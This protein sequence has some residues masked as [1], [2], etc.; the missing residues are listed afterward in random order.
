MRLHDTA[1]STSPLLEKVHF[2]SPFLPK[3]HQIPHLV[4]GKGM[5]L[6]VLPD[7]KEKMASKEHELGGRK[8]A[9]QTGRG[10]GYF[11]RQD[12]PP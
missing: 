8:A 7:V 1:L 5:L 3:L 2:Q 12:S 4:I 6:C 10:A 11:Q 9:H